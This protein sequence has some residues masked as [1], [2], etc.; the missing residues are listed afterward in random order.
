[1]EDA[2]KGCTNPA[3]RDRQ[4]FL[5]LSSFRLDTPS[6]QNEFPSPHL[7]VNRIVKLQQQFPRLGDRTVLFESASRRQISMKQYDSGSCANSACSCY[8]PRVSMSVWCSNLSWY[9]IFIFSFQFWSRR[10]ISVQKLFN[11]ISNQLRCTQTKGL[12]LN[13]IVSNF[14]R[15]QIHNQANRFHVATVRLESAQQIFRTLQWTNG[16]NMSEKPHDTFSLSQFPS[17]VF[18]GTHIRCILTTFMSF[19]SDSGIPTAEDISCLDFAIISIS[20]V[21]LRVGTVVHV[22]HIF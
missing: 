11:A 1:M 19:Y 15:N 22:L 14:D 16:H 7:A 21:I 6:A 18:L 2:Y 13:S 10:R 20:N 3:R 5:K 17:I 12:I 9:K 8:R 4:K